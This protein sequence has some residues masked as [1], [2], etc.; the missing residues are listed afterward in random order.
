[1]S[2]S[3]KRYNSVLPACTPLVRQ[4]YAGLIVNEERVCKIELT[5]LES[6]RA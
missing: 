2:V 5:V 4:R 1:M 6:R 3:Q